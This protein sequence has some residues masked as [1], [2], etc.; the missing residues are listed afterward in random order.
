VHEKPPDPG[1]CAFQLAHRY[2]PLR[3]TPQTSLQLRELPGGKCVQKYLS[4]RTANKLKSFVIQLW[5]LAL[6]QNRLLV[7]ARTVLA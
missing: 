6:V 4:S 5:I 7:L 3:G 2:Q 1:K